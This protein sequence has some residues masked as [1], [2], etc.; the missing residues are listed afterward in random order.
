[1]VAAL[2]LGITAEYYTKKMPIMLLNKEKDLFV[3]SYISLLFGSR[4]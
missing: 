2:E 4:K 1:M 3:T